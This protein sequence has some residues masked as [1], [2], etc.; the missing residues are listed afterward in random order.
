MHPTS[1]RHNTPSPR[2]LHTAGIIPNHGPRPARTRREMAR[3]VASVRKVL[4]RRPG[5]LLLWVER[6]L[7]QARASGSGW[8]S[9]TVLTKPYR[10]RVIGLGHRAILVLDGRAPV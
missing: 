5:R 2:A 3:M 1:A 6:D 10:G 4:W 7:A 9:N 8:Y